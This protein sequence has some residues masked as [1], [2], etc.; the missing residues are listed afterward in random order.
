MS[1]LLFLTSVARLRSTATAVARN[2]GRL[3]FESISLYY[4]QIQ[5]Q[6]EPNLE[7]KHAIR[8][9]PQALGQREEV[10]MKIA[11]IELPDQ[12]VTWAAQQA[13]GVLKRIEGDPYSDSF[14]V[15]EEGIE[16]SRWLPPFEPR[17][18][19]CIGKNYAGHAAETGS[20]PPEYPILFIKNPCAANGH[21]EP[22][23]IPKVC[24]DEIDFECELAFV[25]KKAARDVPKEK[26]LEYVL[27][28]TAANDVSAR[29]WQLEK[30]GSQWNRGKSFDT[31]APL[32]PVLVTAD[33]IPDPSGLAIRTELNGQEVQ[34]GNTRDMIFDVPALISFLS[35]DTTLLPGTVVLSGT[36]DGIG[37]ARNPR[38]TMKPGDVVRVEI[39]GI[40]TLENPIV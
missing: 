14:T 16:P 15:T 30:G 32:G 9:I 12:K 1:R 35:Q 40:G 5:G 17:M 3:M 39:E 13:D 22:V 7:N 24:G 21:L 6:I 18:I 31:F 34:C 10:R 8:P 33:E 37:W 19:M 28:Y 27:G 4:N 11:R 25:I 29:I 36:P 2:P 26:A 20:A 23:R 38:L